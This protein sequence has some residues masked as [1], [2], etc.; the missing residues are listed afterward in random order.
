MRTLTLSRDR[1][2]AR[3]QRRKCGGKGV[4]TFDRH[5]DYGVITMAPQ[6][7]KLVKIGNSRGVRLPKALLA[8]YPHAD[9]FSW[10]V[11]SDGVKLR[12]LEVEGPPPVDQ[13][14]RL[15]EEALAEHGDDADDFS[16]WDVTL[17]DGLDEL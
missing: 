6:I 1:V 2:Q 9:S 7:L 17:S 13:W 5:C 8:S 3:A 15:I 16:I 12:P 10:N 14:A 4:L 11:E